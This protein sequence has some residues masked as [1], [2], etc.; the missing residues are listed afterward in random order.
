MDLPYEEWGMF[1]QDGPCFRCN[2]T[3]IQKLS[4][5]PFLSLD[6]ERRIPGLGEE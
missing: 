1:P 6:L 4:D 3:V 5:V 2:H